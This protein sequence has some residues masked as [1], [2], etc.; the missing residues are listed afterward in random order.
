MHFYLKIKLVIQ[1][2][3][4]K[5]IIKKIKVNNYKNSQIKLQIVNNLK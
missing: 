1:I 3:L 2:K 5:I 4:Q